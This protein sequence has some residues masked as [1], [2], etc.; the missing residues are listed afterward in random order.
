MTRGVCPPHVYLR[1]NPAGTRV[2]GVI[3]P[4][5]S[6]AQPSHVGD[7]SARWSMMRRER[8][9]HTG[10]PGRGHVPPRPLQGSP[11]P[12]SLRVTQS[13][14]QRRHDMA[15]LRFPRPLQTSLQVGCASHPPCIQAVLV[16]SLER[17][18]F[19]PPGGRSS[20]LPFV[21]SEQPPRPPWPSVRFAHCWQNKTAPSDTFRV[22]R[23]AL[24]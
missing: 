22:I 24:E 14:E 18:V 2:T 23:R 10:G 8:D 15:H 5:T 7:R 1:A 6:A 3:G 11:N 4:R 13:T 19:P 9:R 20:S 16:P 17:P 21:L 12:G